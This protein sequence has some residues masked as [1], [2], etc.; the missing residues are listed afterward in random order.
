MADLGCGIGGPLREITRFSGA[1]II[2]VNNNEYQIDRVRQLTDEA[3]LG[4][5]A[6]FFKC[7]EL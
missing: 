6:E 1:T 5:L 4:H 3:E 7:E 2:G